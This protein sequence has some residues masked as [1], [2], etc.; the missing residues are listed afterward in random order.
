MGQHHR[1]LG[2]E[3]VPTAA[4]CWG[5]PGEFCKVSHGIALLVTLVACHTLLEQ[6]GVC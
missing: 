4:P 2:M 1:R 3:A 5:A 6:M